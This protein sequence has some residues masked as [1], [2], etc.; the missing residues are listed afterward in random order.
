VTLFAIEQL[1]VFGMNPLSFAALA[2]DLDCSRISLAPAGPRGFNP[3]GSAP[4]SL[5]EDRALRGDMV[6]AMADLG[7]RVSL[8]EGFALFPG[9]AA[10]GFDAALDMACELAAERINMVSFDPDY[11]RSCDLFAEIAAMATG[12]GLR[13][14]IETGSGPM[15]SL[16]DAVHAVRHIGLPDVRLLLDC[17]HVFRQ[18]NVMEDVAALDPA[19]IGYV[20]LCDVPASPALPIYADEAMY[21]RLP[22]GEGDLPLAPFLAMMPDDAPIGL[23]IPQRGLAEAGVTARDRL[24]H[25]LA[26]ASAVVSS[27]RC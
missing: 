9:S 27:I 18:G 25:C 24:A 21:E 4:W 14:V 17:M 10:S 8:M 5:I 23:E 3:E 20:Q 7:V 22:P 16:P 19:M 15:R 11:H 1:C 2:A 13:C 6:R 12:R 26:A